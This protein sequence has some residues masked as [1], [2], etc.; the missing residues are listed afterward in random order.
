MSKNDTKV[1]TEASGRDKR[2]FA[3]TPSHFRAVY[4]VLSSEDEPQIAPR[5]LS[6]GD[7][8]LRARFERSSNLPE[9][10]NSFLLNI[11]EKL[12]AMLLH[13]RQESI[14]EYFTQTMVVH[15]VSASGILAQSANLQ[16]GDY[17][18]VVMFISEFPSR[19]ASA[20]A[21]VLRP[22]R[23][24][25]MIY[26]IEFVKVRQSDREELVRYVFELDRER[27]RTEKLK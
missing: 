12:D 10:V 14:M 20:I 4:R 8:N 16:V 18:E 7:P 21:R 2:S 23:E 26:A 1:A 19:I 17:I 3:R 22:K 13:M 15:E 5:T 25:E 27:I 6:V 24:N 9:V 11:D